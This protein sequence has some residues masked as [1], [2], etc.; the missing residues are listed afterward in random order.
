MTELS[1]ARGFYPVVALL[2]SGGTLPIG[3]QAQR[4]GAGAGRK[5]KGKD[6]GKGK[7]QTF[8]WSQGLA[9]PQAAVAASRREFC[10]PS[11]LADI[12]AVFVRLEDD[13]FRRNGSARTAIQANAGRRQLEGNGRRRQHG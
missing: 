12:W 6:K 7:G 5:G 8:F 9:R 11:R 2:P 4:K 10:E 1:R 3:A 13:D